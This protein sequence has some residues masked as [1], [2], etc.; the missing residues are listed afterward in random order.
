MMKECD[1]LR[2][3]FVNPPR[4]NE[5]LGNNPRIIE[6]E[7]GFNPPLGILY[8]A[9]YAEKHSSHEVQVIDSQVERLGYEELK[10]RIAGAAPDVV[11]IT[12]MT[13]TLLDVIKTVDIVKS[14]SNDTVVVLGGPHCHLFP[15]E[16]IRLPGVDY[17]VLGEGERTFL[18]LVNSIESGDPGDTIPGVV[19]M[20]G[21]TVING[22]CRP[23]LSQDA[24]DELPFPARHLVPYKEYTSLLSKGKTV[25]TMFTSR[26]CPFQCRFCDRPQL[27]KQ[28]RA[29]SATYVVDEIEQCVGMG[30][31]EFL[32]YDDTFT[33]K[34][35]RVLDICKQILERGLSISFDVRARVDTVDGEMLR[36]LKKAGCAGIHY[37]VEAGNDRI[38][39]ALNKGITIA[40]A[41][42]AFT[43]TRQAGI[44]ILAYWMIGNPG[45]TEADIRQT[46]QLQ[47]ELKPDYV[48]MTTLTPFP[49]T[50]VYHDALEA[51]IVERDVWREFARNPTP[52]F[53][54]PCWSEIFTREELNELLVE[55]YKSFYTRPTYI[56]R[57]ALAV[58][59]MGELKK[60]AKAALHVF[61][62]KPE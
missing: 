40:Q 20:R 29:H 23:F 5:I 36:L 34:R 12:A 59:G 50:K 38:L 35:Q 15:E 28:F 32:I 17:V 43:L 37:G 52:G 58:R 55:G 44:P 22:G 61:R 45:E 9:A 24:L 31:R 48:H 2:I 53:Q 26:G 27:G 8:V 25:T 57:R 18:D 42:E 47:R 60:K 56:I 51:G 7:R 16:T 49:G 14:I 3:L 33:V 6:E 11:G 21:V 13:L 46:F 1:R 62:M 30:I 19:C 41:R 54:P 10:G 39:Q 4:E